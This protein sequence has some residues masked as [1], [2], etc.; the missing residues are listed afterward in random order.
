M[1]AVAAS[2]WEICCF[3]ML[4]E[5]QVNDTFPEK[6]ATTP[7]PA[8]PA[9]QIPDSS[10]PQASDNHQTFKGTAGV[11]GAHGELRAGL[12]HALSCN[13]ATGMPDDSQFA[14]RR[15]VFTSAAASNFEDRLICD[16]SKV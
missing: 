2:A 16:L 9:S 12:P 1:A 5:P 3:E 11:E 13:G 8:D 6:C 14:R 15:K 4:L 7:S 10:H